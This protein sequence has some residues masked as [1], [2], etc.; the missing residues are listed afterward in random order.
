M[1]TDVDAITTAKYNQDESLL[2]II[3]TAIAISE[4]IKRILNHIRD[5]ETVFSV[6]NVQTMLQESYLLTHTAYLGDLVQ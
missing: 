4:M 1:Q 6:Y 3:L 5:V 2:Q